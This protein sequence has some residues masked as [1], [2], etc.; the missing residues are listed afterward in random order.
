MDETIDAGECRICGQRVAPDEAIAI[1]HDAAVFAHDWHSAESVER[2]RAQLRRDRITV[3]Q[4]QTSAGSGRCRSCGQLIGNYHADD[5][6][7]LV[8]LATAA[9]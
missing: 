8:G 2:A 5:C 6:A 9:S 4:W 7:Q 1:S 3:W